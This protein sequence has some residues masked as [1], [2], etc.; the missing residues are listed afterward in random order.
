ML[1]DLLIR[2]LLEQTIHAH[3]GLTCCRSIGESLIV[4]GYDPIP[5]LDGEPAREKN[6]IEMEL[7]HYYF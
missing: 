5:G 7:F 4:T 1:T 3:F 6:I 2:E